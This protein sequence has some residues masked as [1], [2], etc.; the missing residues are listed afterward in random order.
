MFLHFVNNMAAAPAGGHMGHHDMHT[1]RDAVRHANA[2][3]DFG[4][5]VEALDILMYLM[6]APLLTKIAIMK[7]LMCLKNGHHVLLQIMCSVPVDEHEEESNPTKFDFARTI[8]RRNQKKFA[9]FI[10]TWW[11]A[12]SW[13]RRYLV[14]S[15][16]MVFA[17]DCRDLFDCGNRFRMLPRAVIGHVISWLDA[18][19]V[20]L[21]LDNYSKSV[22]GERNYIAAVKQ[23]F[24]QRFIEW[25]A[26]CIELRR[27]H[28]YDLSLIRITR[29]VEVDKLHA[30]RSL[31]S[32]V[33]C[34]EMHSSGVHKAFV[35]LFLVELVSV[36]QMTRTQ[37]RDFF[38]LEVV[39]D[40]LADFLKVTWEN[41]EDADVQRFHDV[42]DKFLQLFNSR[43]S[44][45]LAFKG[46]MSFGLS[47]SSDLES[48]LDLLINCDYDAVEMAHAKVV[49]QIES[50]RGEKNAR[51]AQM[52]SETTYVQELLVLRALIAG[53]KSEDAVRASADNL[54]VKGH[55]GQRHG[56][57]C[58]K[59]PIYWG[60]NSFFSTEGLVGNTM[61]RTSL[62]R[63]IDDTFKELTELDLDRNHQWD[64]ERQC[65]VSNADFGLI[66]DPWDGWTVPESGCNGGAGGAGGPE[67]PDGKSIFSDTCKPERKVQQSLEEARCIE[68]E[69]QKRRQEEA[70]KRQA[71]LVKRK[72]REARA[73]AAETEALYGGA[74]GGAGGRSGSKKE[75]RKKKGAK[76]PRG[77]PYKGKTGRR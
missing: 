64:K 38:A 44:Y 46:Q 27:F 10:K 33:Q 60:V 4:E 31:T 42:Y 22:L 6:Y 52:R 61:T 12:D 50:E 72:K 67:A 43:R 71:E 48:F 58:W 7:L 8:F 55:A 25:T 17:H 13:D 32:V 26:R 1:V 57:S 75:R 37:T 5:G 29:I 41:G 47:F 21:L 45:E 65:Y 68:K 3:G 54:Y 59:C 69:Q 34:E 24:D 62:L 28:L 76:K 70:A 23:Q 30:V 2:E 73:H 40:I 19:A 63:R 77:N 14:W 9:E 18:D 35:N 39:R 36:A 49:G 74:A 16:P 11:C 51:D 20:E 53:R 66:R 15:N 56:C